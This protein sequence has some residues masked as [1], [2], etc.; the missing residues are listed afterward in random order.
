MGHLLTRLGVYTASPVAFLVL[1]AYAGLW[2]ILKPE[3]F[4]WHA[5]ATLATWGMTLVIQRAEHRDT[6]AIHAKLDEMLHVMGDARNE[7]TGVD[8]QE[9][10]EIEKRRSRMRRDD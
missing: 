7:L 4:E 8:E 3:T 10:E 6:Q 1:I 9:P 5:V 2:Y